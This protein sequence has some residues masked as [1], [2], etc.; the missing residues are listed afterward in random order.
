MANFGTYEGHRILSQAMDKAIDTQLRNDRLAMDKKN[1]EADSAL[2]TMQTE[3]IRRKIEEDALQRKRDKLVGDY[4]KDLL[5]NPDVN[6]TRFSKKSLADKDVDGILTDKDFIAAENTQKNAAKN[7]YANLLMDVNALPEDEQESFI[8]SKD[9]DI[10]DYRISTNQWDPAISNAEFINPAKFGDSLIQD[11]YK[12]QEE[13]WGGSQTFT[14]DRWAGDVDVMTNQKMSRPQKLEAQ[15]LLDAV[16][17]NKTD[18]AGDF[19]RSDN[20]E[21]IQTADG[22]KLTENDPGPGRWTDNVYSIKMDGK[23]AKI[24][25]GTEDE[26]DWIDLNK[27]DF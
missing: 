18:K 19:S 4:N 17:Q 20:V 16:I 26:P 3:E 8:N 22:W 11:A 7:D 25:M 23:V 27:A 1:F 15:S 14:N 6:G 24:N 12:I 5:I 13:N 2:K 10:T 21:I 9:S